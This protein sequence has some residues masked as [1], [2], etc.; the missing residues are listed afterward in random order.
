MGY[1]TPKSTPLLPNLINYLHHLFSISSIYCLVALQRASSIGLSTR[2]GKVLHDMRVVARLAQVLAR[3]VARKT[4]SRSYIYMEDAIVSNNN[5]P[6]HKMS[7]SIRDKL[8][9]ILA[10]HYVE[11]LTVRELVLFGHRGLCNITDDELL[12]EYESFFHA[13]QLIDLDNGDHD[14]YRAALVEVRAHNMLS[15]K[16]S[17]TLESIVKAVT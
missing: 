16:N 11:C 10:S 3:G 4:I 15:S 6:E 17:Y 5:S 14:A 8:E 12:A 9:E 1:I 2:S 13:L 7:K